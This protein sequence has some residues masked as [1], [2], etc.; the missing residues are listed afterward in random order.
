MHFY[1]NKLNAFINL[2]QKGHN[3]YLAIDKDYKDLACVKCFSGGGE[4]ITAGFYVHDKYCQMPSSVISTQQ[5]HVT[6]KIKMVSDKHL[7]KCTL[8]WTIPTQN[9]SLEHIIQK[10]YCSNRAFPTIFVHPVGEFDHCSLNTYIVECTDRIGRE[11][12]I[13]D[14]DR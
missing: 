9:H 8:T 1:F 10:A 3:N 2:C 6:I 5:H 11:T 12:D 7:R 4:E 14:S 13:S